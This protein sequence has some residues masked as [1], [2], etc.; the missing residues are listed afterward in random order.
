[1]TSCVD[2]LVIFSKAKLEPTLTPKLKN[3]N[4][5]FVLPGADGMELLYI[6]F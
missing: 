5:D 2:P 4:S 1:M 3:I 6:F